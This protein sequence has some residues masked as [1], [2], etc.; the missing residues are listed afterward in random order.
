MFLNLY[1]NI[2]YNYIRNCKLAAEFYFIQFVHFK[3]EGRIYDFVNFWVLQK[4]S[5]ETV[6]F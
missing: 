2:Y 1:L 6:L 3:P 5:F 4:Q